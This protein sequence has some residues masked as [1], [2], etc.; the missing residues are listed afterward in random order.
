MRQQQVIGQNVNEADYAGETKDEGLTLEQK[1]A[2]HKKKLKEFE[3]LNDE[4]REKCSDL[5]EWLDNNKNAFDY[6]AREKKYYEYS[7]KA[8]YY[9]DLVKKERKIIKELEERK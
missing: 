4:Y 2:K 5:S 9:W 1:I 6:K 8:D 7:D 3:D